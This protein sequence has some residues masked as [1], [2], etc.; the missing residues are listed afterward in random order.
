MLSDMFESRQIVAHLLNDGLHKTDRILLED[1]GVP[2]EL[3]W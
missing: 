2:V 3:L 1:R